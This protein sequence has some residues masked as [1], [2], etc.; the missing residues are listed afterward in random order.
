M[1]CATTA[2]EIAACAP[3]ALF[4]TNGGCGYILKP[5]YMRQ[6]PIPELPQG[7]RTIKITVCMPYL[8]PTAFFTF[9]TS[10]PWKQALFFL[11]GTERIEV[12]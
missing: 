2:N 4:R 6:I 3:A 11:Y 8:L 10:L 9:S 7:E 5:D 1:P 12:N